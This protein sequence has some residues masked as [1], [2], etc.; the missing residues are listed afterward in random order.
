MLISSPINLPRTCRS[1]SSYA[2]V[3]KTK[4]LNNSKS[5]SPK[6]DNP[7]QVITLEG[8]WQ[9]SRFTIN[10]LVPKSIHDKQCNAPTIQNLVPLLQQNSI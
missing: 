6:N 1:K 8:A 5:Y 7:H 3:P 10:N 4:E 9:P 2:T